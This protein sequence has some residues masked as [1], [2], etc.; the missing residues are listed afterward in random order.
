[1]GGSFRMYQYSSFRMYQYS[2]FHTYVDC[3]VTKSKVQAG[4][5]TI[6]CAEERR[7]LSLPAA[8]GGLKTMSHGRMATHR[9]GGVLPGGHSPLIYESG[10]MVWLDLRNIKTFKISKKLDWIYG[11]C[12]VVKKISS[13]AYK[14][15]VSGKIHPVFYVNLFK[16]DPANPRLSQIQ[17]NT[18]Q[19]S[20]LINDYK[21]YAIEK[22]LNVYTKGKHKKDKAI[23]KW[24]NYA[25]PIVKPLE[26]V[27]NTNAYKEILRLKKEER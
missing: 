11:R 7:E 9:P 17:D 20:V 14:L 22:I 8:A 5:V 16:P 23:V 12:K 6:V 18:R 15:N 19:G 3:H 2:S 25:K 10:D 27:K 4:A 13:H 21:E 24:I 26:F 1:V